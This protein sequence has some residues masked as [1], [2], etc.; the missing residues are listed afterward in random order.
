MVAKCM[1][2]RLGYEVD[3]KAEQGE[4]AFGQIWKPVSFTDLV[5]MELQYA[6][7]GWLR[8]Q[9]ANGRADPRWRRYPDHRR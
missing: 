4:A 1:L 2:T 3:V 8:N 6:G 7:D 5:L 9:P